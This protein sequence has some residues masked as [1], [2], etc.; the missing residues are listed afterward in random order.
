MDTFEGN[1]QDFTTQQDQNFSSPADAKLLVRFFK[2]AAQ[3]MEKTQAEGRAIFMEVEYIQIMVAG[4]RDSII[5]RPATW[6][7]KSRFRK[8]YEDWKAKATAEQLIGT[9]LEA[10]GILSLAQIEEFRYYGIRT[11]EHIADLRDDLAQK[12]MGAAALKQRAGLFIQASKDAA[13][14]MKMQEEL[15]KRDNEVATL[16]MALEEQGKR[17]QQLEASQKAA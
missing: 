15:A 17:L 9:P 11:V 4:D 6:V 2:K 13:P 10:W 7:D 8:Q 3:D 1:V 14:M 16:K 12:I 5:V